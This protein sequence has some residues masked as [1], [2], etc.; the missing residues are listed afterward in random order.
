MFTVPVFRG[1]CTLVRVARDG[2]MLE[3]PEYH[4]DPA[5]PN[6]S[7]VIREWGHDLVDTIEQATGL[8]TSSYRPLDRGRG[9]D[10]EF[11]EVFIT[12]KAP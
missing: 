7:L 9:L 5:D 6:G 1:R 11:L 3:P 12:R 10:G 4:Q 8:H 2:S